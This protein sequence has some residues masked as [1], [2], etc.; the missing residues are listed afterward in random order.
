MSH[1]TT[2]MSRT[3]KKWFSNTPPPSDAPLPKCKRRRINM[4]QEELGVICDMSKFASNLEVR[5][6][7][8]PERC[9]N[10]LS[11]L[12]SARDTGDIGHLDESL[13]SRIFG[14]LNF[15]SISS[16]F[17][18]VARAPCLP[19]LNRMKDSWLG[20]D[21]DVISGSN[22]GKSGTILKINNNKG[23]APISDSSAAVQINS[24]KR[25]VLTLPMSDLRKSTAWTPQLN[26]M[27]Q[28]LETI[29]DPASL[30]ARTI[31]VSNSSDPGIIL[32]T[33]G[34]SSDKFGDE[35][36]VVCFDLAR[37]QHPGWY[38]S[39][40]LEPWCS[41]RLRDSGD[42]SIICP[43]ELIGALIGLLTFADMCR[44][45]KIQLYIFDWMWALL[46][47]GDAN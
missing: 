31:N 9:K 45:R 11:T 38:G 42:K 37:P 36:G 12:R 20:K 5:I 14:K 18:R 10:I 27:L 24:G 39:S 43:V 15:V 22:I 30:P 21:V 19:L 35:I 2:S 33:D 1:V 28:F 17:G 46:R 44:N 26:S 4:I 3:R 47:T 23:Q 16:V 6:Q 41:D 13:A 34:A 8:K 25:C 29:L 7:P 40:K 32:Y